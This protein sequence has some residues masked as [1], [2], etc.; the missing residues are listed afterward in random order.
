M[1]IGFSFIIKVHQ[2]QKIGVFNINVIMKINLLILFFKMKIIISQQN[3]KKM[4]NK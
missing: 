3:V 2:Q 1:K 4:I